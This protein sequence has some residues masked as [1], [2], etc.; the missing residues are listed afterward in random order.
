M[1]EKVARLE[2]ELG[3][4][5]AHSDRL[6]RLDPSLVMDHLPP[7]RDEQAFRDKAYEALKASISVHGQHVPIVVRAAPG[8]PGRYE[9]AAG[10]R[11]LVACR[12]LGLKVLALA[13]PLDDDAMLSL[14]YRENAEREDVSTFERGRWFARLADE[15]GLST[16]AI[17]AIV[18]LAQPT[19]SDHLGLA[20]LPEELLELFKDPRELSLADG[21]RL[22]S[23]LNT[24][25]TL[26]RMAAALKEGCAAGGT[27][28]QV[29]LALRAA[30]SPG[31]GIVL[32][33]AAREK[34]RPIIGGDGRRLGFLTRSGEQ[35]VCRF[36]K[37]V[38]AEAINWLADQIPAL[39][40]RWRSG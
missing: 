28:A 10:R 3:A 14:Q 15:R 39:L 34:R 31:A 6:L 4:E 38:E 33:P 17:A 7:D 26:E 40:E 1:A 18:G 35:W 9:I 11:R 20:R 22:R 13:L 2:A 12:E 30:S 24:E 21:R 16:T 5:R 25:G 37:T 32:A 36:D 23:V 29:A 27:K 19:V 8:E